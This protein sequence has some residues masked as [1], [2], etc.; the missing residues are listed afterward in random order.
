MCIMC[1]YV[2]K[3]RP[4]SYA[5]SH[6]KTCQSNLLSFKK[7]FPPP[8]FFSFLLICQHVKKHLMVKYLE[9]LPVSQSFFNSARFRNLTL[10][11]ACILYAYPLPLIPVTNIFWFSKQKISSLTECNN[12]PNGG[13]AQARFHAQMPTCIFI[14]KLTLWK[15]KILR[16]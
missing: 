16:F 9:I 3:H 5:F 14:S 4:N 13:F 7:H 6:I 8:F 10:E 11:L 12:K 2:M 15:L 1:Q